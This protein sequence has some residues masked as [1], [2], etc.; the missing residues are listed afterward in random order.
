MSGDSCKVGERDLGSFLRIG[1]KNEYGHKHMNKYEYEKIERKI[2]FEKVAKAIKE[3]RKTGSSNLKISVFNGSMT[4][5]IFQT[6][7]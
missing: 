7:Q 4:A 3:D 6:G 2:V 5:K 1:R